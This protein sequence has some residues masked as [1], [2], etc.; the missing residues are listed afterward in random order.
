MSLR[1]PC[2]ASHSMAAGSNCVSGSGPGTR[3]MSSL[4]G[5]TSGS[6]KWWVHAI[7]MP[8]VSSMSSPRLTEPMT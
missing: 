8:V 7:L 5:W 1:A 3:T 4:P 2:A 6:E